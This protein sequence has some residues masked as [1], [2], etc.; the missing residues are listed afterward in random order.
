VI[1]VALDADVEAVREWATVEPLTFPV[2]IDRDMVVAELFGIVNVPASVWIDEDGRIVRPADTA[3]GDDRFRAFAHVDSSVH[4]DR[5]RAWVRDGVRDLDDAG[6]REYQETPSPETQLARLHRRVGLALKDLGHDEA[7]L[8]QL[9][10]AEE[11]A[12]LDWT[13]R[14]GNMP[15]EGDDPF[16][17]KFFGFVGEWME[18]G[19]PG[20]RLRTG[21]ED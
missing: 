13:I 2:L 9:K 18:A 6:V 14:R 12:P 7:G 8:V 10:R 11:L 5:L 19:Q 21:R 15:L 20:F 4:H 1:A 17:E 3:M 16:G